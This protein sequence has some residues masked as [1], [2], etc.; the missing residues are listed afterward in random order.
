MTSM[1]QAK[2]RR[3]RPIAALAYWGIAR[4]LPWSPR[5]GGALARQVRGRLSQLMLDECGSNVNVE[6]GAWFGSGRGVS[7]GD[8]SA[9]GL[10][11]LIIGPISIG[12]NVMMGPRCVLL[13]SRHTISDPSA[14]MNSQGFDEDAPI[15]IGDDV[16][17]G[18]NVTV[19]PGRTI[20]SGS[21]VGAGSVVSR[22]IGD[23]EV[24][25]GNPAKKIRSR[26]N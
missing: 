7:L 5:P 17:I 15:R 3:F 11:C 26:K 19:L 16:W 4:H 18:A 6:R 2:T 25:A 10:D 13:A 1:A 8:N 20:G 12:D 9:I 21:I 23:Y 14:P 24:W 22:D